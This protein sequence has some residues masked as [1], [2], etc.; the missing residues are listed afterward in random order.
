M[1]NIAT[2]VAAIAAVAAIIV[3]IV[4]YNANASREAK[5]K[6]IEKFNDIYRKTFALRNEI[7][8]IT[9]RESGEEYYYEL[10]HAVQN[11][12][13]REKILDY[14][15]EMEDFFFLVTKH[16][17]VKKSFESLM[18]KALYERLSAFYGFILYYRRV[19]NNK[20]LF[21]NYE[22]VLLQIGGMHK[23][24][25][26]MPYYKNKCYI[27][28]RA[29]DCATACRPASSTDAWKEGDFYFQDSITMFAED[30]GPD[31]FS[32]RP[33]Q[34]KPNKYLAPFMRDK[35][36][37]TIAKSK[38]CRFM[39]YNNTMAYLF[40]PNLMDRFICLNNRE[41]LQHLNNKAEMKLWLA[42]RNIPIVPYET[43]LGQD[44][45]LNQ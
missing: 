1:Q 34:N 33:N 15:T 40:P 27:G 12:R 6:F 10:D 41:L 30:S 17:S 37:H 19:T 44:I 45:T 4:I 39:F 31:V 5:I 28:I 29:S 42:S 18:S 7:S 35:I 25:T 23:I 21:L 38:D 11:D 24:I 22:K 8:A 36:N 9:Q 26:Q 43:F 14:L 2:S 32:V 13:V 20:M 16:K 3:T